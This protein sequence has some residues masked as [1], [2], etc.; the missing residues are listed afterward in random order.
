MIENICLVLF[1]LL[2]I[3]C[4]LANIP[5]LYALGAGYLVFFVYALRKR[6]TVLAVLK[7]SLK[8]IVTAKSVVSMFLF[9]G[10]TTALWRAA[11]TIPSIV[12]YASRF[13]LP[14]V[15]FLMVFL[16]NCAVSFLS[17]TA[18]GTAA[19]MGIVCMTMA[20]SMNAD[21]AWTG[22][23]ILSGAFFGDRCSPVSSSALLISELTG[24]NIF[25][26]IREMFRTALIPFLLSCAIYAAAGLLSPAA[27]KTVADLESVFSPAFRLGLLPL[28]PAFIVL[29]LSAFRVPI[30]RT[31]LISIGC[32]V[33]ICL[34]YQ[35][36]D[37]A[38]TLKAMA[39]GY[40]SSYARVAAMMD[41]G[42]I[43]SMLKVAAIVCLSSSYAGIFEETGF[44]ENIKGRI[45]ALTQKHSPFFVLLC[46]SLV[47]GMIACNQTLAIMLGYQLCAS[48]REDRSLLARDLENTAV[49]IAPL[50]PWS[51]AASVPLSSAAAPLRSLLFACYLYLIPLYNLALNAKRG[52]KP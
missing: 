42:G 52:L 8:G 44:L 36:Q 24:T 22:G 31:L 49:V 29:I 17:G 3:G 12:C 4:V 7:M 51:I 9:I 43:V 34:V 23:A 45:A 11:G 19:T 6:Y 47:S 38:S 30:K 20:R 15:F 1:A 13:V 26:N 40:A 37:L 50:I 46:I 21:A 25:S 2:L 41:G 32:A 33:L 16:L 28:L 48:S 5:I 35:K 39:F 10:I 27:G 14:S 18:F